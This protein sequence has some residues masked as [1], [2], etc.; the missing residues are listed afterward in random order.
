MQ[1]DL[2][3]HDAAIA[4]GPLC[5]ICQEAIVRVAHAVKAIEA[6]SRVRSIAVG[7]QLPLPQLRQTQAIELVREEPISLVVGCSVEEYAT[8]FANE[9]CGNLNVN[10]FRTR[11]RAK[12]SSLGRRA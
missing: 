12:W 1:C 9:M 8:V 11:R 4:N 10:M 7:R 3:K 6:D 2:C 5:P